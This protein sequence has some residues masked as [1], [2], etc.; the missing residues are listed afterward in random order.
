M[1]RLSVRP[2]L[3]AILLGLA[4]SLACQDGLIPVDVAGTYAL[5]TTTG[6]VGRSETPVSGSLIL[7]PTGTAER[8]VSVRLDTTS[9]LTELIA[10]GTYRVADSTV[11]F[12]LREDSGQSPYVWEPSATLESAG[13][14]R[15]SYPRAADGTI[16]EI[17]ERR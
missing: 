15:L 4:V 13:V 1:H 16:V 2:R 12:A 17:Y 5:T 3:P 11:H 8:R 14:L 6:A 10:I 9:A 7:T